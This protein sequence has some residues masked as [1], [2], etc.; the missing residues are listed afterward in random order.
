[1]HQILAPQNL[2]IFHLLPSQWELQSYGQINDNTA[3]TVTE[4]NPSRNTPLN[5]FDSGIIAPGKKFTHNFDTAR[6]IQYYCTLHPT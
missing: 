2:T 4:G 5:G 1:M 6:T 3:H